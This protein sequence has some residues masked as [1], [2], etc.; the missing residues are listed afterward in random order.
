M[1]RRDSSICLDTH[2]TI[3]I[4]TRE[5]RESADTEQSS[6]YN[7]GPW[8]NLEVAMAGLP[9]ESESHWLA[10]DCDGVHPSCS[11]CARLDLKCLYIVRL[12]PQAGEKKLYIKAL[13]D[14]VAELE[15]YLANDGH[16]GIGDDHWNH[17]QVQRRESE[18]EMPL[19]PNESFGTNP[20]NINL[21]FQM[22]G[23]SRNHRTSISLSSQ[24]LQQQEELD[25][26]ADSLLSVVRD[27]SL[28]ASGQYVGGTSTIT[29]G[30]VLAS[31]VNSHK[32]EKRDEVHPRNSPDYDNP[33][34]KSIYSPRLADMIGPMFVSQSV[35]DRL[36]QGFLRHIATR[37]PTVHTPR[38][39]EM[40][41]RRNQLHDIY[42]ESIMH[43]V[44]ATG[45][46]WLEST[47]EMG[48]FYSDQ[49]YDVAFANMG[50]ILE[51]RDERSLNYLLLMAVY[52]T[53]APRD[54]GA[55]TYTG[56]A[57]RLCI[58][59]GL[60]RRQRH[61]IFTIEAEL[62]KRRFWSCYYLDRDVS[63]A[64]GRPPAI[65]DNDI[66]VELPL[67]IDEATDS[68]LAIQQA[69]QLATEIPRNPP[70]T[71][72]SFVHRVRLKR[73]ESEIQ[74]LLYRVDRPIKAS[75]S[76]IQDFLNQLYAWRD[77][78]PKDA[79]NFDDKGDLH[80]PFDGLDV[81]MVSY[82]RCIRLLLY[83]QLSSKPLNLHYI[84]TCATSCAGVC[85]AYRRLHH[86]MSVGFS[87]LSIQ[88][89]FLSGLTLLYCY[90]LSPESIAINPLTD[91][92]IMLYVMTE[93]WPSAR[94]YRDVFEQIKDS[95]T[96]LVDQA[97]SSRRGSAAS[98]DHPHGSGKGKLVVPEELQEGI[99]GLEEHWQGPRD[100]FEHMI[101]Q[102]TGQRLGFW[103]NGA[104]A[105][106]GLD[107]GSLP[108][109]SAPSRSM[110]GVGEPDWVSTSSPMMTGLEPGD[111][112][113]SWWEN[114]E[115]LS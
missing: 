65:S 38:V 17:P 69:A 105:A 83:P 8:R 70:T 80:V 103:E 50:S 25:D 115:K 84:Q 28:S 41:A 44:Y 2:A 12:V 3:I 81:Y 48:N 74:H 86:R 87:A 78:L 95:V 10:R 30:R 110:P 68:E 29:I 39:F 77:M 11:S 108:S 98:N 9:S 37:Y 34:P 15:N 27:L 4:G 109:A 46:R 43:L 64:L 7:I 88:S 89:V 24:Q 23:S 54:P 60:H 107:T 96:G 56:L 18:S 53:R 114:V 5:P 61:R 71:L 35:A 63:L 32:S 79:K 112:D 76:I 99:R 26:E 111:G 22:S 40:H 36:I 66:D 14:R 113:G 51:L 33:N 67:D 42:E 106:V 31:V 91:C 85:S 13:E 59:L 49:H 20:S 97:Q 52:C 6:P 100:G 92:S 101:S 90:W 73:I 75:D 93:R 62:N 21:P 102:M 47:G 1:T 19:A 104:G 45:G 16:L 72:T 58:E 82:H 57:M 55:W 94:K